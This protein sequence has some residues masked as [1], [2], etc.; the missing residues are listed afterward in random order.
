M[1][2]SVKTNPFTRDQMRELDRAAKE[3]R[4]CEIKAE[5]KSEDKVS[6]RFR[7]D[8]GRHNGEEFYT[9]LWEDA[10]LLVHVDAEYTHPGEKSYLG[11]YGCGKKISD[12]VK[13]GAE[14]FICESFGFE[15]KQGWNDDFTQLS[16]F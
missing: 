11:G 16:F 6:Y 10:E 14:K 9:K 3:R 2:C 13:Q 7:I 5:A 15:I 12:L 1:R 8:I 4:V